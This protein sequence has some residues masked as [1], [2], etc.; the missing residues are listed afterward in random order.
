[1]SMPGSRDAPTTSPPGRSPCAATPSLPVRCADGAAGGEDDDLRLAISAGRPQ[2]RSGE[3]SSSQ[4]LSVTITVVAQVSSTGSSTSVWTSSAT[5]GC[6]MS[7]RPVD[8]VD[9]EHRQ[10]HR[11]AAAAVI[12]CAARRAIDRVGA[13]EDV[14][15][16]RCRPSPLSRAARACWR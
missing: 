10:A 8:Q 16:R 7:F 9:G 1:M 13:I 14:A 5:P 6:S 12:V 11:A 2:R 15:R 4:P 3:V